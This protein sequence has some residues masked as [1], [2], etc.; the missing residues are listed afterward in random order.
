[1]KKII[2]ITTMFLFGLVNYSMAEIE[3]SA[4]VDFVSKYVWRGF[5]LSDG[6]NTQPSVSITSGIV[7]L[8]YWGSFNWEEEDY[9]MEQ[10]LYIS[11]DWGNDDISYTA[12]Y[13]Y[14]KFPS[15][16]DSESHEFWL[17]VTLGTVLSPSIT[18][19]FDVGD[20]DDGG[21]DGQYYL[22]S[23]GHDIEINST[24]TISLGAGLGYNNE[25]FYSDSCFSD[26]T[27]SVGLNIAL[28]DHVSLGASLTY[29]MLMDDDF[30]DETGFDDELYGV[31]SISV[32]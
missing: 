24:T 10:D 7:T 4:G 22:F 8:G 15:L 17:G 25:L 29:S 19:Y 27:P 32:S 12:G 13:T 31:I 1:M 5:T 6:L 14:Y 21:A 9:N 28:T 26:F 2:L 3:A 23:I 18:A 20:E 30:E 16:G 11:F